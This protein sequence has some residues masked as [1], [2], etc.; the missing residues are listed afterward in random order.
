MSL[1]AFSPK[2][3]TLLLGLASAILASLAVTVRKVVQYAAAPAGEKE[4]DF[5]FPPSTDQTSPTSITTRPAYPALPF[6]QRGGFIND[7][8][9]LNRTSVYGIV[10]VAS[11]DDVANALRF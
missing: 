8:S 4:S 9:H 11:D 2:R 1:R 7:A 5:V 6:A 10:K 3:R